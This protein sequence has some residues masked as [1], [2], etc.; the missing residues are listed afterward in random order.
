MTQESTMAAS[1]NTDGIPEEAIAELYNLLRANQSEQVLARIA[2]YGAAASHPELTALQGMALFNLNKHDEALVYL[3]RAVSGSENP[4]PMWLAILGHISYVKKLWPE[5]RVVYQALKTNYPNQAP[6]DVTHRLAETLLYSAKGPQDEA[7]F[8]AIEYFHEVLDQNRNHPWSRIGLGLAYKYLGEHN[9][10]ATHFRLA[11]PLA[12][13]HAVGELLKLYDKDSKDKKEATAPSLPPQQVALARTTLKLATAKEPATSEQ[14]AALGFIESLA[15]NWEQ[16]Y[17]AWAEAEKRAANEAAR[18][19]LQDSR[20]RA[21]LEALCKTN[22]WNE[23]NNLLSQW[24]AE[25]PLQHGLP[26]LDNASQAEGVLAVNMSAWLANPTLNLLKLARKLALNDPSNAAAQHLLGQ[27]AIGM[28]LWKEAL[29]AYLN[30]D[31]LLHNHAA[32]NLLLG[33]CHAACENP[34]Q[35]FTAYLKSWA[36]NPKKESLA[37]AAKQVEGLDMQDS[38]KTKLEELLSPPAILRPLIT[39]IDK[40]Q[41]EDQRNGMLEVVIDSLPASALSAPGVVERL[42]N[43]CDK[44]EGQGERVALLQA[45]AEKLPS[46]ALAEAGQA[47]E[48]MLTI[49]PSE[50]DLAESKEERKQAVN[51]IEALDMAQLLRPLP[52][53]LAVNMIW[54]EV[55]I[56]ANNTFEKKTLLRRLKSLNIR[57]DLEAFD[58]AAVLLDPA[59]IRQQGVTDGKIKTFT[60]YFKHAQTKRL[61]PNRLFDLEWYSKVNLGGGV[62]F[63]PL[64]HFLRASSGY[65]DFSPRPNPYFDCDWYREKYLQSSA[66]S[67]PLLHYLQ[68]YQKAGIQPCVTFNNQYVRETQGLTV[69]EDPLAYYLRELD[70]GGSTF[71]LEGFSP[72]PQFDRAYYLSHD[73][74]IYNLARNENHDPFEHFVMFGHKEGRYAYAGQKYNDVVRHRVLAIEPFTKGSPITAERISHLKAEKAEATYF[75]GQKLLAKDF[76]YRPL[77]SIVVPVYQVKPQFLAEMIASV[78]QQTY[79]HWQLCIVDDASKRYSAEINA[80]LKLYSQ[81]D[82]RIV[83]AKRAQNGHICR[84]SN[85][86]LAM[87]K[88]EFVALLDHDDLLAPDAL[89]EVV[90]A[91]NKDP[92]IDVIYSDEDKVDTWGIFSD[93]YYK[94]D[95]SPHSIWSRMYVC[96]LGVYR[97]ALV[98]QVGGFRVGYEGSQDYDLLLRCAGQ[99][100]RIHHIPKVL[101]HWRAHEESTAGVG[102]AAKNYCAEAGLNAVQSALAARGLEADVQLLDETRTAV[103]VKPK[104]IGNPLIDIIIPSRNAAEMLSTCLDSI[105]GKSTYRNFKV[106]VVDNGSDED[107]FHELMARWKQR[108]PE[109]FQVLRDDNPFNFSVLNNKAV[110]Q[111][112]G[113]YILL[114]NNDT[115]VIDADWLEGMLGYAQLPEVGA[116][117]AKLFYEDGTIQHAGAIMGILGVAGHAMKYFPGNAHGYFS[118][119]ELITNYSAVTAACLMVSREKYTQVGGLEEHLRVAFNDVDFC[120]KLTRAGL[121]NVYLPFVSLYHYES[122]SRGYEDTP[123]KQTRFEQEAIFMRMKWSKLLDNDP[124]Y[125]PWLTITHENMEYRYH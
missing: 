111:T 120:L 60:D 56:A 3:R 14:F 47:L 94:P 125:S 38:F 100:Q 109:R 69:N 34:N 18:K 51:L 28:D 30:L 58:T 98:D 12:P 87:A 116:V 76:A 11:L 92:S 26:K 5:A 121:Y 115:E 102:G 1:L 73:D 27:A 15:Q 70:N 93:P 67:H 41:D 75:A 91:L 49:L 16:S 81:S 106:T 37:K 95:W 64:P 119:L 42:I 99:T 19:I 78:M 7:V 44:V 124:F 62:Q 52:D 46:K 84:A 63:H 65:N 71:R 89:F 113:E 4:K 13:L 103:I 36:L 79:D 23:A 72:F 86:C 40:L 24:L 45:I 74:I 55:Q 83:T 90:A 107:D 53:W 85:D 117:G 66:H 6:V 112:K 10:A 22:N 29:G 50:L 9:E 61:S 25:M 57:E 8:K 122:K 17:A 104:V 43:A 114:L 110:E 97:K 80:I 31:T 20:L 35:A 59:W 108:E 39:G 96:H 48:A 88:G 32:I 118:N 2:A 105:F 123:E 21:Q 77:I 68:N 33:Q 101:Y 82:S 54:L